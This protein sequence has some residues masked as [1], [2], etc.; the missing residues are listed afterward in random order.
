MTDFEKQFRFEELAAV[1]TRPY[2]EK[3]IYEKV[4]KKQ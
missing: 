4:I 1:L 2:A 3:D